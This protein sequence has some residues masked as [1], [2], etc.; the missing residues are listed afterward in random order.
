MSTQYGVWSTESGGFIVTSS[1]SSEEAE[2]DRQAEIANAA[3]EDREDATA[4]LTVRAICS[5]HEEQPAD[6]C[7]DCA[8]EEEEVSDE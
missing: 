4:D 2:R 7:E 5:D 3:P 6:G 8:T 1:W